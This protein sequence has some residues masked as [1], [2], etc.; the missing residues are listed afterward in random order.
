MS[1]NLI[2][3]GKHRARARSW[4]FG[5]AGT[6]TEQIGI[7]FDL[8]D[9]PDAGRQIIW[10]GFF[11]SEENGRRALKVM[12]VCGW[13]EQAEDVLNPTG[14]DKNEVELVIKHE[15][16]RDGHAQTRVAFVNAIG[17][18]MKPMTDDEKTRLANKL[19]GWMKPANGAASRPAAQ[20]RASGAALAEDDIPF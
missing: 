15:R 4:G 10:Y 16:D 11:N 20:P 8:V 7:M 17:V 1:T 9:G 3:E 2:A 12:R 5:R 13:D 18:I 14:L 19:R 6:G